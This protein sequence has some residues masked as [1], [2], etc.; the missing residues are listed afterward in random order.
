MI[1]IKG[2]VSVIQR[3]GHG[4]YIYGIKPEIFECDPREF[5]PFDTIADSKP[6]LSHALTYPWNDRGYVGHLELEIAEDEDEELDLFQQ[7]SLV[8]FWKAWYER[9]RRW[10]RVAGKSGGNALLSLE[11]YG[12]AKT[13][14]KKAQDVRSRRGLA[15]LARWKFGVAFDSALDAVTVQS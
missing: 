12:R 7:G 11:P 14:L 1:C 9:D 8:V 6:R 15:F 4:I 5:V 10:W 3:D 2:F 13:A